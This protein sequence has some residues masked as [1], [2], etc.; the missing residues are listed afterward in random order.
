MSKQPYIHLILASTVNN[1]ILFMTVWLWNGSILAKQFHKDMYI[2]IPPDDDLIWLK[3]VEDILN[4]T[5]L[6]TFQCQF[7]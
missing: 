1:Y 3:H 6:D 5:S 4:K 7:Y 2:H